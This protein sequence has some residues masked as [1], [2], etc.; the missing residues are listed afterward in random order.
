M[1]TLGIDFSQWLTEKA[2]E[3]NPYNIKA[4]NS[5]EVSPLYSNIMLPIFFKKSEIQ[6]GCIWVDKTWNDILKPKNF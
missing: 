5:E 3:V 1:M 4:D 2:S 6:H